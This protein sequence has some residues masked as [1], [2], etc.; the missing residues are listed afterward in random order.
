MSL[1]DKLLAAALHDIPSSV[2]MLRK[3]LLIGRDSFDRFI[4][5]PKCTK[6][7]KQA[8]CLNDGDTVLY[9]L[10]CYN[11]LQKSKTKTKFCSW[12]MFRKVILKGGDEAFYRIITFCLRSLI[13]SIESIFCRPGYEELCEKWR[14]RD[15]ITGH[16]YYIYDGEV[17]KSFQKV[18]EH[19][20]LIS[21]LFA[22]K[23]RLVPAFFKKEGCIYWCKFTCAC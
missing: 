10:Q 23:C 5:C 19:D 1:L 6:L 11:V 20:F 22:V 12:A 13:E 17:W 9:L 14:N 3:F 8:D 18:N 2:Y 7:Y 21:I 16:A 4:M 15:T